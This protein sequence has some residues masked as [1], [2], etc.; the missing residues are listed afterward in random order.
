MIKIGITGSLS[1]GKSTVSKIISKNKYP[2]YSAD[3][4]VSKLYKEKKFILKLVRLFNLKDIKNIKQQIRFIIFQ[5]KKN[6]KKLENLIHPLVSKN[7][8]KFIKMNKKKK[9]LV[10]EIPLLTEGN[11]VKFFDFIIFVNSKKKLSLKRYMKKTKNK[12]LFYL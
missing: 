2:I 7:M 5:N 1:S 12:K 8:K 11:L 6:L 9:M 10:F 4:E 3:K